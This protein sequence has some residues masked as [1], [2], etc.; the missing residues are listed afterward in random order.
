MAQEGPGLAVQ[1]RALAPLQ[2]LRDANGGKVGAGFSLAAHFPLEDEW[3][4]RL[5]LGH[6]RFPRGAK[7]GA[8]GVST[9]VD[10]SHL[11]LEVVYQMGEVPGPY[12]FGGLGGYS[13]SVKETD[14]ALSLATTRR[15][16]HLGAS[17]GFGY[18]VTPHLDV[19]LKGMGGR[20]D[21]DF[22]AGWAGVAVSWR[23]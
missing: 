15:V 21:P 13:W 18:R 4:W 11:G 20:V 22:T 10:V 8:S 23:F 6:D 17:L 16:A 9:E 2:N 14:S 12:L 5:D 3:S 19:E 1:F 7:A